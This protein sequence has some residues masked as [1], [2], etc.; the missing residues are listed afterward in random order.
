VTLDVNATDFCAG[1]FSKKLEQVPEI[2]EKINK[3]LKHHFGTNWYVYESVSM[4]N[5]YLKFP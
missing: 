3:V 4:N 5:K 1:E 2:R